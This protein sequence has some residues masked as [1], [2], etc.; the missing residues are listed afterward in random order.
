MHELNVEQPYTILK[1]YNNKFKGFTGIKV[2]KSVWTE[3]NLVRIHL[4]SQISPGCGTLWVCAP[5]V[6][7]KTAPICHWY[8]KI[9]KYLSG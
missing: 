8:L 9:P 3:C 6:I 1:V 5:R 4:V 2:V 7:F